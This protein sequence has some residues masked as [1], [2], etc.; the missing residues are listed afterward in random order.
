MPSYAKAVLVGRIGRDPELRILQSGTPVATFPLAVDRPG[1]K[2][3]EFETS[4]FD[5]VCWSKLAEAVSDKFEKGDLVL[6][7]AE[8]RQRVWEGKNGK[9]SVVEFHAVTVRKM[10]LQRKDGAPGSPG[11]A[12]D[13][14]GDED[15]G[16]PPAV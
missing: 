5:V 4:W 1:P 15:P 13:Y 8:P 14:F 16:P 11:S 3:G 2:G 10:S 6:V 7:E 9:R 12:D